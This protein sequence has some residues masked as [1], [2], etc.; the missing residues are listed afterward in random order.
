ML[1]RTGFYRDFKPLFL[2]VSYAV[3][4]IVL[5]VAMGLALMRVTRRKLL[6]PQ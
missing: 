6:E 1:F 5:M 3:G 4:V 2:D